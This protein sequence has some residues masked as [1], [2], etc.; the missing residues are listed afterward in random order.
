MITLQRKPVELPG[1]HLVDLSA[2]GEAFSA[3]TGEGWRGGIKS[4]EDGSFRLE[5][6]NSNPDRHIDAG[7]GDWLIQDMGLRH[8]TAEQCTDS[9]DEVGS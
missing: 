1:W 8:I 9:Y 4:T 6:N 5:L 3:L 7:M 2:M